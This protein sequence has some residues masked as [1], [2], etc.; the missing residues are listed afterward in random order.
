M[1]GW[2]TY[3]LYSL[4]R[5]SFVENRTDQGAFPIGNGGVEVCAARRAV[6]DPA[7]PAK[8]PRLSVPAT[9]TER[10]AAAKTA[11]DDRA[12]GNRQ[13]SAKAGGILTGNH[14]LGMSYPASGRAPS[15]RMFAALRPLLPATVP[16]PVG[17][18]R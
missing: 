8:A 4:C 9:R 15:V 6:P 13:L 12:S 14:N 3:W 7:K 16:A 2:D 5:P 11:S 18:E 10:D 1:A 17:W